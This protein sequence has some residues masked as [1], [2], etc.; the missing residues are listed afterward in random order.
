[1]REGYYAGAYWLGRQESAEACARRAERFFHLLCGFDPAWGQWFRTGRSQS[2][3][4]ERRIEPM[5]AATFESLFSREEHQQFEDGFSLWAWNGQARG[6][7]T[8]LILNCGSSSLD[9]CNSCTLNPPHR[10]P[11]A[12]RVITASVLSQTLKAM[13]MAW[14][15]EWGIATSD[16]HRD[17]VLKTAAVGTFVGW[18]MY[19]SRQRGQ[20]PPMPEPVRVEPVEDK[21]TLIVL[22]PER[23]MASNP[24]HVELAAHVQGLLSRAGLLGPLRPWS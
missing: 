24:E 1:M 22:T 21:G 3:A 9:L 16:V 6:D 10:G 18:V 11:F 5:T 12:E 20:V 14:E 2:Q 15:P 19:F 23:F 13:V 4:L 17:E 8:G 7:A